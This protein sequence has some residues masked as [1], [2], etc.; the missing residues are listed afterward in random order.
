MN[1]FAATALLA[2]FLPFGVHA[3]DTDAQPDNAPRI[4][5]GAVDANN[6][7]G[8]FLP[9]PKVLYRNQPDHLFCW[10]ASNLPDLALEADVVET[11][12]SPKKAVFADAH[13]SVDGKTHRIDSR[14]KVIREA[15][16]SPVVQKC[17]RMEAS[18]PAGEYRWQVQVNGVSYPQQTFEFKSW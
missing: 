1:K 17:W 14:I 11:F 10:V 5:Y 18:D 12:E 9:D 16:K 8:G 2:A 7:A 4:D 6:L 15:G 3:A 13:S